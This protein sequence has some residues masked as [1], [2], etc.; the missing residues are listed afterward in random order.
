MLLALREGE[1]LGRGWRGTAGLLAGP[2]LAAMMALAV[3]F[4]SGG[5]GDPLLWVAF[6]G[7]FSGLAWALPS[8]FPSALSPERPRAGP[9]LLAK[10]AVL[11]PPLAVADAVFLALLGLAGGWPGFGRYGQVY[12]TLLLCSTA[13]LGLGLLVSASV[14]PRLAATAL[15]VAVF[16]LLLAAF[17][18]AQGHAGWPAWLWTGIAAAALWSLAMFAVSAAVGFSDGH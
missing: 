8:V 16:P 2:P 10:A 7:F 18:V 6:T 12:L 14:P 1:V 15:P 9:C 13:A 4:R 3:L 17:G 11:L 5:G